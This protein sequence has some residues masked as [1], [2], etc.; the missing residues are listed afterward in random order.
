[1]FWG[2]PGERPLT[3]EGVVPGGGGGKPGPEAE[4]EGTGTDQFREGLSLERGFD[5]TCVTSKS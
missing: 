3:P 4:M 1:M 5:F 2:S